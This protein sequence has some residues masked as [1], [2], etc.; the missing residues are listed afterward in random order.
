M[1]TVSV[2]Y[3]LSKSLPMKDTVT[4]Q[5]KA[6]TIPFYWYPSEMP[7]APSVLSL[8]EGTAMYKILLR[9]LGAYS[10]VFKRRKEG[11]PLVAQR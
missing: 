7:T 5:W 6:M 3:K 1:H 8:E 11:V 10:P 2:W 4:F 9:T